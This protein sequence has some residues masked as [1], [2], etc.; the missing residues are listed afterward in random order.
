[1]FGGKVLA[2]VFSM[3]ET[4]RQRELQASAREAEVRQRVAAIQQAAVAGAVQGFF[5]PPMTAGSP[6]TIVFNDALA[7]R[8]EHDIQEEQA[9]VTQF[10]HHPSL[11][12]LYHYPTAPNQLH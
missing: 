10:V 6:G 2:L 4:E 12:T 8:L 9:I 1:M 3:Q 5:A 7:S 11:S